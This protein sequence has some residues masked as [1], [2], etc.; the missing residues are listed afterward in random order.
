MAR[1]YAGIG[2]RKTPLH[3]LTLMQMIGF[4]LATERWVLRSGGA[5]GAD[6][7][8][9]KGL[10]EFYAKRDSDTIAYPLAEIYVPWEGFGGHYR[11]R[12]LDFTHVFT[13]YEHDAALNIAS[14][15]HPNWKACDSVAKLLHGRNVFQIL[16]HAMEEPVEMLICWSPVT[17]DSIKG[18]TRT[19]WEIAKRFKVRRL[20]NLAVPEDFTRAL[21][22]VG[23]TEERL[24]ALAGEV[25]LAA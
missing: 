15:I 12:E 4:K 3:I 2:S 17:G 8:F 5:K 19:A 10:R 18:G 14:E 22:F 25:K 7:A 24:M 21:Q 1:Y 6:A 13:D 16:G 23:L 9:Y 11:A 20:I